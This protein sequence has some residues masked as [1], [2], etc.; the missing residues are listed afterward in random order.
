V[1]EGPHEPAVPDLRELRDS[2]VDR[3]R[4]PALPRDLRQLRQRFD[5]QRVTRTPTIAIVPIGDLPHDL[6]VEVGDVIGTSLDATVVLA[7]SLALP[8]SAYN[9]HREQYHST[10]ILESLGDAKRQ[11]WERML[12][13]VD[14]DLYVPD[15]N[16]VFGEADSHR[17]VAV[18]SLARLRPHGST[19]DSKALFIKRAATEG[20][21]ELGHT[22]GLA[23]CGDPHCVMWFSNTLAESDRKGTAFCATHASQLAR[24]RSLAQ[25]A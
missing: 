8:S 15:L 3:R 21:H 20:I 16:F 5:R 25:R 6:L 4:E 13:V 14:V 17:G 12:G 9:P 18:F 11:G 10:R 1:R 19:A 22:H 24:A 2:G 7:D 23:H